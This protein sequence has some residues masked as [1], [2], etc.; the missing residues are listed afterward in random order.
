MAAALQESRTTPDFHTVRL[1]GRHELLFHSHLAAPDRLSL[2]ASLLRPARSHAEPFGARRLAFACYTQPAL[3][4]ES[5]RFRDGAIWLGAAS[6][7][8]PQTAIA[9]LR[10]WLEASGVVIAED[11]A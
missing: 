1:A 9:P 7:D 11:E 5:V 8:L 4:F 2:S 3:G 10:A 6:F